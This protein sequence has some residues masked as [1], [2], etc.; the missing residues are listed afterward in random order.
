[1]NMNRLKLLVIALVAIFAFSCQPKNSEKDLMI[2]QIDSLETIIFNHPEQLLD[3]RKPNEIVVLYHKFASLYPQ[4]SL[5]PSYW[6]KSSQVEVGLG[7]SIEAIN[8]LDSLIN[9]YPTHQ[10]IPAALQ[11][12]AFILDDRL[13]KIDEAAAVLDYLIKNFAES[14]SMMIENAKAYRA[15]LGKS[16][17]QILDEIEKINAQADTT[18]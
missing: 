6:Y 8:S 16:P 12:K 14:D 17:Q 5:S 7:K 10:L 11:F 9:E 18:L 1:M 3:D 13:G 2:A 15:S 4:D